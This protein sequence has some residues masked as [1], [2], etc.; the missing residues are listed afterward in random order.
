MPHT[1]GFIEKKENTLIM[2]QPL[3]P[4][5]WVAT[6]SELNALVSETLQAIKYCS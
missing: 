6:Q 4:P 3:S 1:F 5:V 2:S